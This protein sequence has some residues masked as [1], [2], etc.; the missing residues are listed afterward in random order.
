MDNNN[1]L[2]IIYGSYNFEPVARLT[3]SI[4]T[5]IIGDGVTEFLSG[6]TAHQFLMTPELGT[7][8]NSVDA[9]VFSQTPSVSANYSY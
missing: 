1:P 5:G 7:I 9:F 4:I 3:A 6:S 2:N 8:I